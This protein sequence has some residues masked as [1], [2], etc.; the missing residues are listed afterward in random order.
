MLQNQKERATL[1]SPSPEGPEDLPVS[2]EE[3][4]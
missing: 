1:Q 3:E 4:E 2:H